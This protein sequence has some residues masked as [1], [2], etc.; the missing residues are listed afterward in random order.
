MVSPEA[1]RGTLAFPNEATVVPIESAGHFV[2]N[3]AA[4]EVTAALLEWLAIERARDPLT[5]GR[6]TL[7]AAA[8]AGAAW[9]V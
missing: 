9:I 6:P 2:Q 8:R 5:G 1:L 7:A 4:E 3:E